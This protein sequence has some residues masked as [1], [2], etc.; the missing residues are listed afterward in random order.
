MISKFRKHHHHRGL[1]LA[2]GDLRWTA[3]SASAVPL[4][5]S[6]AEAH[7]RNQ[8]AANDHLS[9]LCK[10]RLHREALQAFYSFQLRRPPLKLYPSTYAHLLLA[11]SALKSLPDGRRIRRHLAQCG[12][13]PPD[14]ILHN[15]LLNMYGKCGATEEAE[16][17]FEEMPERNL[18][19]WTSL[20]TGLSH[21]GKEMEAAALYR[22]M[23]R[24]G[25]VS[26]DE[27]TLG[28]SSA[29]APPSR[30]A[31][32][33]GSSTVLPRGESI[34]GRR[35]VLQIRDKDLISWGSIVAGYS[36]QGFYLEALESFRGMLA[37]GEHF[38]N[39]F[40]FG[41]AFSACGALA[42]LGYGEEL[43]GLC[44]KLSWAGDACAGSALADMYAKC[45]RLGAARRAF[46]RVELPDVAAWNAIIGACAYAGEADEAVEL[47]SEMV[48]TGTRPDDLTVRC[49]L[50]GFAG[51]DRLVQGQLLHAHSIKLGFLP[52][53][54]VCNTLLAMYGKCSEISLVFH[55]FGEMKNQSRDLVSW[56]TLLS[57]CLQENQLEEVLRHL[58][59]LMNSGHSPDQ[60]TISILH[61][62]S[63]KTGWE[64]NQWVTNDLIDAYCKCGSPDEARKLLRRQDVVAWSSLIMGYAQC[65]RG[66]DALALFDEMLAAGVEPNKVTF[67]G[68]LSAC[69]RAG[70][71]AEGR[72]VFES[73][74]GGYGV[75]PT[76]EHY[77]CMIDLLARAGW[78]SEAEEL[79]EGMPF[80]PDAVAWKALLAS[81]AGRILQLDPGNSAAHV[82]LCGVYASQG[83]WEEVAGMRRRMRSSGVRKAQGKSW[84][85]VN[86][87][88]R[89]FVVEDR[90][91]PETERIYSVLVDL[92]REMSRARQEAAAAAAAG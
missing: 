13:A 21:N 38:P 77:S 92:R 10:R 75:E 2:G 91:H 26:P 19:S 89:V 65:G 73:M 63:V 76:R 62:H 80:E 34:R 67:V 25:G 59:Q 47:F 82:L 14:V 4:L 72:R 52:D 9:S 28:A 30:T 84:I 78:L 69:G 79:M 86:G 18:V 35:R 64:A 53:L 17:L 48:A 41:S 7:F 6:L 60:I 58:H 81:A 85:K 33:A 83:R 51:S 70:L 87:A 88:V 71:V 90:S 44:V 31:S 49:L 22:E 11:C 20:L 50:L 36:Q 23:L 55:L 46:R 45:G 27:F 8:Q 39:E 54:Q 29:P 43:H 3:S 40:L 68:V 32:S 16:K 5:H 15:H 56:N 66:R 37:G 12:G 1:R 61:A 42:R 24:C 74:R 57:A